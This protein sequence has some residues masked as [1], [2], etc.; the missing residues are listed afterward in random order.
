MSDL[1]PITREEVFYQSILNGQ[2][3]NLTPV[4]RQEMYLAAIAARIAA[5]GGGTGS[6]GGVASVGGIYPDLSGNVAL[7]KLTFTGAVDGSYDGSKAMTINVENGKDGQDGADGLTPYI[8][9]NGNWWIGDTDTGVAAGGSGGGYTL[10]ANI[11]TE[12]DVSE[13]IFD[14]DAEGKP[15][16]FTQMICIGEAIAAANEDGSAST[17][18]MLYIL[19]NKYWE[20]STFLTRKS[21]HSDWHV[22][23]IADMRYEHGWFYGYKEYEAGFYIAP[24]RTSDN[25]KITS[26][27]FAVTDCVLGAGSKFLIYG[28]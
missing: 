11:I 18:G 2:I 8:G 22:G 17:K 20:P 4:T 13:L 5:G 23:F 12:E 1:T 28:K 9:E 14:T 19:P 6:G 24:N 15:F 26:L 16:S 3:P 27:K 10:V 7:K 25:G 21:L